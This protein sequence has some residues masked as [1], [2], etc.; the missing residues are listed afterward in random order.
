MLSVPRFVT[1]CNISSNYEDHT[2]IV[3]VQACWRLASR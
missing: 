2:L 1:K 3:L